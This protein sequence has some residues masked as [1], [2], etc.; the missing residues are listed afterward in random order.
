[1]AYFVTQ[2]GRVLS[3]FGS[4]RLALKP[5]D[6]T[7]PRAD[8]LLL[9]QP[10]TEQLIAW[11]VQICTHGIIW[12]RLL[13][14]DSNPPW[15]SGRK[16]SQPT[17]FGML[18]GDCLSTLRLKVETSGLHDECGPFWCCGSGFGKYQVLDVQSLCTLILFL[19]IMI[20]CHELF[21]AVLC[22]YS[23][24]IFVSCKSL[25]SLI[26]SSFF[27]FFPI[28]QEPSQLNHPYFLCRDPH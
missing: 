20:L 26:T 15:F 4:C 9:W 10:F 1:M 13:V 14:R 11:W 6:V 3:S 25:A 8:A 12:G 5:L 2:S 28:Q 24:L 23:S 22:F 18:Q 21:L 19:P 27:L 17:L 7:K 16:W